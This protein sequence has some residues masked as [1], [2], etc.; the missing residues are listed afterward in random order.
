MIKKIMPGFIVCLLILL[1]ASM[2]LA[3]EGTGNSGSKLD[4]SFIKKATKYLD[5]NSIR[6]AVMNNGT[7][8]RHPI[9]T[10][11]D[12]EWPK[13]TGKMICYA[14]G[15]WI[16]GK[17]ND[18]IRT[19]CADYNVEYQPGLILPDGTADDPSK[20]EYRVYK[21]HINY[22]DGNESLEIDPWS[23]W[24]VNQ[25]APVNEDGSIKWIGD[26]MLYTV[27][28][29]LDQNLHSTTYNTLPIGIELHLLVF[30]FDR[31]GALGNSMFVQY[32]I[33]NKGSADLQDAYI[34]AWYD[35]D[36]GG[37]NDDLIAYWEEG[38]VAMCYGGKPIDETYGS[39]PP[40]F[41]IDFFQGP[42]VDSP[43][44][45]VRLPDGRVFYDKKKL[46][47]T[48][49]NKYY[50]SNATYSDPPYNAQGAVEVYNYM[51]GHRK[52]GADWINPHTGEVTSFVNTGDPVTGIGWLSTEESPPA[53]VRMLTSAGPFTLAV[54]DTQ[55]V[56]VG[57]VI[58]QGGDRLSSVSLLK[59]Y[60]KQ[61]QQAYDLG[62]N[63]PSPPL[64]PDVVIS[65]MDREVML[66]W[67][68]GAEDYTSD[69]G[70]E[71]E[72]YN[73]YI[74][75]SEG[76]PWKLVQVY[77]VLNGVLTVLDEG[78]D[79]AT[80]AVL[81]LPS[82]KGTDGGLQYNYT[83][84]K[85]Y[86]GFTM[87]NG[88]TYYAAVTSY[89]F[90]KTATPKV[91]ESSKIVLPIVPH[92]A[93]PGTVVGQTV[94][95]E[96]VPEHYTGTASEDKYEVWVQIPDPLH[97][98]TAAYEVTINEDSTWTMWR[99]GQAIPEYTDV[100][101]YGISK[102]RTFDTAIGD[103]ID[104]YFGINAD[105]SLLPITS[106]MSKIVTDAG[107]AN[108]EL[109]TSLTGPLGLKLGPKTD[110]A[111]DGQYKKGTKSAALLYNNLEIRFT[112]VLSADSLTVT[113]GGSMATLLFGWADAANFMP[114]HPANPVP[115][116]RTPFL[117]RVP[118]EIWDV[119]RGIQL[120]ASFTDYK[121]KISDSTFVPTWHPR[122]QCAVYIVA[123][124]YDEQVHN[125][126]FT[127]TDTM[128]TWTF[129]YKQD[130]TWSTGDVVGLSF[131]QLTP[132]TG[133]AV[134]MVV[135]GQNV[136]L[137][138]DKFRFTIQGVTENVVADAKKRLDII[139][140]FPNP[141]LG[142]NVMERNLH[143]EH[144]SFINMPEDY[145]I[146]I[147]SLA[148]QLIRTLEPLDTQTTTRSWD[149][150]NENNLPV[151]SGFY[152]A[153]IDVPGVGE[154]ILKLAVVFRQQRLKNL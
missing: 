101:E 17:V 136:T 120:N 91:L 117:V 1:I 58:A 67:G 99:N 81:E 113:S 64:S 116:S 77:D 3:I 24:P 78:Y 110:M 135:Q 152:F 27:M 4:K 21:V 43:G 70:Y 11:S 130:A 145:T 129:I 126:T 85:D 18:Q 51:S 60:D 90:E 19:A 63:V 71:F 76:G 54:G 84:S 5:V 104:F 53:D 107:E 133:K 61:L 29:D 153:H 102:D 42:I 119:D 146:R 97:V 118:F 72:G 74:G 23:A 59:V 98:Q 28:N 89:A 80:N 96:I 62:F 83:F 79:E 109:I 82:A 131:K 111:V 138:P 66:T 73:V 92:Q 26:E 6:C 112:G 45:S 25:G 22:P 150:R 132:V 151:A 139:N 124:Q 30:A 15:M 75:D 2:A 14:A 140:V 143:E 44:D 16:S 52:D 108:P 50:N 86:D 148:G 123:S 94:G 9:T 40:A 95:Q 127:G 35:V 105:F 125:V 128:A 141:Y 32:T 87:A 122:G 56:V 38:G 69:A 41:G 12:M 37:A 36:N 31:A 13:G 114:Q 8:S 57:I 68:Q 33:I 47:A 55:E 88:R 134:D 46:S 149:L 142:Y 93:R 154:K 106:F 39:R 147:F 121:Q 49:F 48:S 65:E 103:P 20:E 34:G 100:A 7:Y 144:V 137:Q 115:G 10:N